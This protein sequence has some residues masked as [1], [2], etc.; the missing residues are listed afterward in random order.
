MGACLSQQCPSVSRALGAERRRRPAPSSARRAPGAGGR[1]DLVWE[2]GKAASES[3]LVTSLSEQAQKQ[4]RTRGGARGLNPGERPAG[5][6]RLPRVQ[7]GCL[8]QP[9]F[10]PQLPVRAE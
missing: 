9:E 3:G 7:S 8:E 2:R 4:R 6:K 10:V 5:Q 1:K